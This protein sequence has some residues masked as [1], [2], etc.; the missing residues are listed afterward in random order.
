MTE[1]KNQEYNAPM[2]EL[3][4]ARVEKGFQASSEGLTP[5]GINEDLISSGESH[6]GSDFD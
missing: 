3:L 4:N 6:S 5:T 2:V 1:N